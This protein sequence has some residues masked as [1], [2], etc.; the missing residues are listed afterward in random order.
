[1][2]TIIQGEKVTWVDF[3]NPTEDELITLAQEYSIHPL[4]ANELRRPTFR[5]KVENYDDYLY[6]ILHFPVYNAEDSS[7]GNEIDFIIGQN[8]LITTRYESIPALEHVLDSCQTEKNI[9]KQ[10]L[11]GN[12][13]TLLYYLL[14]DLFTSA[15]K[16][17]EIIDN[18]IAQMEEVILRER[19]RELI[20]RIS[21]LRREILD[22]RRIIQPQEEVLQ[23]LV[24]HG[25][26][27]FGRDIAPY[28]N[29]IVGD[30]LRIR[31]ILE[32]HKETIEALHQTNEALIS[33]RTTEITKNLTLMA[34]ITLPLTVLASIF[35]M[36]A[37]HA[38]IV[39]RQ[40]DFW[41]IIAVMVVGVISMIMYFRYK[42]WL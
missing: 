41:I 10:Y 8:F 16:G 9:N 20:E 42:K 25:K 17:V 18:N 2:Q 12:A 6:M 36:N 1:M 39:G 21:V 5:P 38:P 26:K 37:E 7:R 30:Y 15:L 35:G 31:H 13:G 34:F 22:F 28:F 3:K 29:N 40:W 27:F 32:N 11:S 19:H 23:S 14:S 24:E 4:V 33:I